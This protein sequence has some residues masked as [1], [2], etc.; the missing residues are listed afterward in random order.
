MSSFTCKCGSVFK[1]GEEPKN[2]CG[3]LK[4]LTSQIQLESYQAKELSDYVSSNEEERRKWIG[5]K[6]G[7]DYP[8]DLDIKEI[9]EDFIYKSHRE[10]GCTAT[11]L[12]PNC[13]RLATLYDVNEEWKFYVPENHA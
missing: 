5:E 13:G 4:P 12:C 7:P 11:F 1:D 6:F 9:I 10:D 3:L 8:N 2:S